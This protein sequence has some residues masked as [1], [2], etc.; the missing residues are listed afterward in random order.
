MRLILT[1]FEADSMDEDVRLA[2]EF[3]LLELSLENAFSRYSR[4]GGVTGV[5][6]GTCGTVFVGVHNYLIIIILSMLNIQNLSIFTI[7][8]WF[9]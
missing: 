7:V 3:E 5:E 6:H 2:P 9:V 4:L 8:L 1:L